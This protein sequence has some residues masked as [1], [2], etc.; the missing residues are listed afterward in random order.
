MVPCQD[1][2]EVIQHLGKTR[3]WMPYWIYCNLRLIELNPHP[4]PKNNC[5]E[6][7][8]KELNRKYRNYRSYAADFWT[9]IKSDNCHQ[10]HTFGEMERERFWPYCTPSSSLLSFSVCGWILINSS[11]ED[12]VHSC[13]RTRWLFGKWGSTEMIQ[14]SMMSEPSSCPGLHILIM[15]NVFADISPLSLG[16]YITLPIVSKPEEPYSNLFRSN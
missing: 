14:P 8:I 2:W 6:S 12:A 9:N 10:M 3:I 11:K 1:V 5:R 13:S 7:R 4:S 15:T 16:W